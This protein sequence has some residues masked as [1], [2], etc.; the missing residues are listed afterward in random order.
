M[1]AKDEKLSLNEFV[2]FADSV[3]YD[4]Q[5]SH[6]V[7]SLAFQTVASIKLNPH[8]EFSLNH[9]ELTVFDTI[10]FTLFIVRMICITQIKSRAKA[11]EFSELYIKKVFDYFPESKRI[12]EKYDS[13]FFAERVTYYDSL[14]T[15]DSF[16]FEK[17][18][19]KIVGGFE[20]IMKYDYAEQYVRFNQGAP[21]MVLDF[22]ESFKI[23]ADVKIFFRAMPDLFKSILPNVFEI[24]NNDDIDDKQIDITKCSREELLNLEHEGKVRVNWRDNHPVSDEEIKEA[25]KEMHKCHSPRIGGSY[26]PS[27]GE[28]TEKVDKIIKDLPYLP[29]LERLKV[30]EQVTN[31]L[32]KNPTLPTGIIKAKLHEQW[33]IE[34]EIEMKKQM[35]HQENISCLLQALFPFIFIGLIILI[36]SIFSLFN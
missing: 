3:G 30:K 16:S 32:Q 19:A 35:E 18:S 1:S 23:S 24:Y 31:E 27:A 11:E 22:P 21:V 29:P 13:D 28:L 10:I 25:L 36:A 4:I 17:C 12:S 33:E 2:R 14:V 8:K 20:E 5:D 9:N 26:E 34:Q 6:P 15:F 7:E